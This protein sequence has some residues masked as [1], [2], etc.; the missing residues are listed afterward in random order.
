MTRLLVLCRYFP[1]ENKIGSVRPSKIVKYLVGTGTYRITVITVMPYGIDTK[2]YEVTEDGVE[3][4]RVD[5]GWISSLLHFKKQGKGVSVSSAIGNA[6]K[7]GLKHRIIQLLFKVRMQL[8]QKA[9]LKCAKKLLSEKQESFDAVFSTYNTRFGHHLALWYKKRHPSTP[10]IADFRD[11]VWLTDSSP[12]WIKSAKRFAKSVA[13]KCDYITAVT[14]GILRTHESDFGTAKAKVVYNGYDVDDIMP[15]APIFDGILRLV[16]TGELYSGQR[17][18]TP[19]FYALSSLSEQGRIDL[20][21]V[22]VRYA[23]NSGG[24]FEQQIK[25][26]AAIPYENS[27]FV[28]RKDAM[29][30]QQE[31]N[32]LLLSSWC[33]KNDKFTLTGKFFEYIGV[34][35]PVLCVVAG[36]ESGC[37]LKSMIHDHGLGFCYESAMHDADFAQMCDFL[38][39]AYINVVERKMLAFAPDKKFTQQFAYKNI[40]EEFHRIIQELLE[41]AGEEV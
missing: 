15:R 41:R 37:V 35:R 40:A 13:A 26:F 7:V 3:I 16:Y 20:S 4:Y 10:W 12:N 25:Q 27:G 38:E 14:E 18:L 33:H 32:I 11:S 17:D 36:E 39:N 19:L 28:P 5:S 1:P 6:K 22:C 21:K 34:E 30:M 8:E 24:I 9:Q 29:R 2:P 31:S 23:G